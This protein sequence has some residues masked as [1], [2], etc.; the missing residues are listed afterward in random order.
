MLQGRSPWLPGPPSALRSGPTPAAAASILRVDPRRRL[1]RGMH[2]GSMRDPSM[3]RFALRKRTETGRK[4][5][6]TA[7]DQFAVGAEL[8]VFARTSPRQSRS[9]TASRG[10]SPQPS[11]DCRPKL[12]KDFG[13]AEI[14]YRACLSWVKLR[15]TGSGAARPVNLQQRKCLQTG[16]H[17]RSDKVP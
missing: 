1:W 11:S 2:H 10:S 8:R 13:G 14:L 16:R 4:R 7:T 6:R 5:A 15:R 3:K 9:S 12:M 17:S